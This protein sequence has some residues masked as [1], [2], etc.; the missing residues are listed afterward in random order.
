MNTQLFTC[1]KQTN[2][3]KKKMKKKKINFNFYNVNKEH[4]Y[5]E[6]TKKND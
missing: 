4:F 2:D 1:N 3:N 6:T 5:K